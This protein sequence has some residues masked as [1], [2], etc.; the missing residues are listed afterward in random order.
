MYKTW[1][2]N[3]NNN[4]ERKDMIKYGRKW[5]PRM[6]I[7]Q[8]K[9]EDVL[10]RIEDESGVKPGAPG[11]FK[12]YQAAV[13]KVMAELSDDELEKAKETAKEWSNN[14]PPPKIQAQVASKK[15]PA[16]MEHFLRE[17]WRQC[18]MRN[19]QGQVLFR[20]HDD[21]EALGGGDSFMKTQD[22]EDIEPIW[23][24]YAQEQFSAGVKDEGRREKGGWKRIRKPAMELEMDDNGM[25]LLLEIMQTKLEE[26]KAI[27]RA[28]LTKHYRI[29]SGIDKAVVPWT[30][31]VQDQDDF[32]ARM[33]LPSGV[34]VKE[35]SKLQGSEVTA[36]L[37]FWYAQQE[38][39]NGPTFLFKAWR[40][41]DGNMVMIRRPHDSSTKSEIEGRLHNDSTTNSRRV[42][43]DTSKFPKNHDTDN[44]DDVDSDEDRPPQKRPRVVPGPLSAQTMERTPRLVKAVKGALLRSKMGALLARM[45]ERDN[46]DEVKADDATEGEKSASLAPQSFKRQKKVIVAPPRTTRSKTQQKPLD[47]TRRVTRARGRK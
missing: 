44:N 37:N 43:Q 45:T 10:Q 4:K 30:A 24:E 31:I 34:D 11:M 21:N 5:T 32:V 26:K 15:G 7:Y 29:Y 22:W 6:V 12:H 17:M 38:E 14:F 19:E 2:F 47:S 8:Q 41:K 9:R 27:V 18:G 33:Y 35:P 40:N 36:L 13:K 16:Y 25:L 1:L 46:E 39:N 28:F 3:N 42:F 20:M 23:Q